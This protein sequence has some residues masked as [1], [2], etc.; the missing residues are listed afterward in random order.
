MAERVLE[1]GLHLDVPFGEYFK[2]NRLNWSSLK[3]LRKT[4]RHLKWERDHG[5]RDRP[6]LTVGRA[7][8]CR[9]LTPERAGE[10]V[11]T[12]SGGSRR[13]K[14]FEAWK[15][16]LPDSITTIVLESEMED[17]LGM[18][19]AILGHETASVLLED[20]TP[21]V[22]MLWTDQHGNACK[23][24]VDGLCD[25][26][27]LPFDIKTTSQIDPLLLGRQFADL[28][29]LGQGEFYAQGL[30]ACG[31]DQRHPMVYICVESSPPY[32]VRLVTGSEDDR[33]YYRG[34]IDEWSEAY[35]K[36]LA[37]DAW[38][39]YSPDITLVE[40]PPWSRRK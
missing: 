4:P 24:R 6:F 5:S 31:W 18:S 36:C 14:A 15:A 7:V 3:K 8:H 38:P 23:G 21:E 39:S 9:V 35:A 26:H 28:D 22:T 29:Y 10:E 34:V 19:D 30:F 1:D 27:M 32:S 16:A 20:A 25:G 13:G 17:V 11:A 37:T 12:W 33:F 40:L 2:L